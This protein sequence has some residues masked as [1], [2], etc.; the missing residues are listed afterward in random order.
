M[1][2]EKNQQN[3]PFE[4][5]ALL[6]ELYHQYTLN[7]DS[8]HPTWKTYFD[9]IDFSIQKSDTPTSL[10][11][12]Q[13]AVK[14]SS[15][16]FSEI[17]EQPGSKQ[18]GA[19]CLIE[20]YR[21]FGYISAKIDPLGQHRYS[22]EL[23][24]LDLY[25]LDAN[26]FNHYFTTPIQGLVHAKLKDI[27]KRLDRTY[28]SSIG[29]E[30]AYV[31]NTEERN[32][33]EAQMESTS[34]LE[35]LP[36]DTSL[37]IFRKLKQ[38]ETF[39]KFLA[40]KYVGKKRFS[41]EGT[42][43]FISLLDTVINNGSRLGI[44][45]IVMGMAHRGR[46]NV[47]ANIFHK[48]AS[49]IFA[50]FDENFNSETIDYAD[51]KYHL[52]YSHD[53]KTL[54][55]RMIHLS[56]AF[57]PSHLEAV[58][59]VVLGSVRARQDLA[60][61]HKRQR[62]AFMPVLVHGDAA[63]MGQGVV[64]ETLNLY[65]LPGY[66]V[67][68]T[69]HIIINNQIGFTTRPEESRSTEYATDLAKAFQIPIFHVNGDDPEAVY[70]VA[71]LALRYRQIFHKD[72]VI[73]LVSYRR[74]GH[75]ETDEPAFTQ[76]LLY[77]KIKNHP[78]TVRIYKEA[79]L[80]TENIQESELKD[81]E[82]KCSRDLEESFASSRK[83]NI[84]MRVDTM[85]GAWSKLATQDS[86]ESK[87]TNVAPRPIRTPIRRPGLAEH[88][89]IAA[90]PLCNAPSSF[91]LHPKL[92]KLLLNRSKMYQGEIGVDWGF[93]ESLS[94]ASILLSKHPI[95][96]SG[97]DC[98]RGTFSHRHSV[99]IDI[100]NNQEYVPL[101]NLAPD[102]GYFEVYNSPLSEFSV[103]GFEYGYSLADP[104]ALV[105]WEAQFGDFAN[106][107]QI[108]FDQFI[109][110]SEV[111]WYR[112]SGLV[113]L[114][115]HGYEG[116]GP[117]HS[118]ARLERLLQ[119]CSQDNVQVCNC[120]SPAQYFHLLRRQILRSFR[121]PLIILSP[122]SL[123]RHPAVVSDISE[124]KQGYFRE[125]LY[126]GQ[127]NTQ[128]Q[129]LKQIRRILFC[130]GK[131]Y[132]DLLSYQKENA[133]LSARKDEFL[134]V[135]VEQLYP[136]PKEQLLSL[137]KACLQ[138]QDIFWVQEEPSNQGAWDYI[139]RPLQELITQ[140]FQARKPTS[141]PQLKVISRKASPS[142][143]AGLFTVHK[144]EQAQILQGAFA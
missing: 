94:F 76:P 62:G 36:K 38:A 67:Q 84:K 79:L 141:I 68:G 126:R 132:Y 136:L 109:S 85:Q 102:Q 7:K 13:K 15:L 28:C 43:S 5:A 93:A 137:F 128:S 48:P 107:A 42:E 123:L 55:D 26:D 108:I 88:L 65:N 45:C 16:A 112:M 2:K 92:K 37:R 144:K 91:N 124:L 52:G 87:N 113:T 103:L 89:D 19:Q 86:R 71:N 70:R 139:D 78:S 99:F 50:E 33:L 119:L 20:S 14:T 131:I 142:S 129:H 8:L 23:L 95:R 105:I 117:E 110:S 115:P 39:E 77:E 47:L 1:Q 83:N 133:E 3:I 98:K 120:T 90:K 69:L 73:D 80:G 60:Q 12:M 54:A 11:K 59:P 25:G 125:L 21:R 49:L 96:F 57:N 34:F 46:L 6:E 44:D 29:I 122:K 56:L 114:L 41:I 74:L 134:L 72:V 121:K 17:Q 81:I 53:Y 100:K 116:Q 111:K 130:S 104:H 143:A 97:Q 32:W 75:N 40:Q 101:K 127:D 82:K 27:I 135:R 18:V 140:S 106:G 64:A 24:D 10:S 35:A 22:K 61:R 63:F 30:Y 58:N 118:S 4:N 51:V 31:R 138:V 9:K 66:E